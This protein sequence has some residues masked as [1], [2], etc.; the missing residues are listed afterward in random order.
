MKYITFLVND[1]IVGIKYSPSYLIEETHINKTFLN[2]EYEYIHYKGI[3]VP[4]IDTGKIIN[5]KPLKKFDGLIFIT[6]N[7]KIIAFKTEGFFKYENKVSKEL[8]P[9]TFF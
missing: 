6:F 2:N 4:T 8:D 1:E 5:D 7:K 9:L 3:K